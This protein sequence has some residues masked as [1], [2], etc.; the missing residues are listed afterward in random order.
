MNIWKD[1]P[2]LVNRET[3]IKITMWYYYTPT[4]MAKIKKIKDIKQLKSSYTAE[5]NV[6]WHNYSGKQ[7]TSYKVKHIWFYNCTPRHY[8][9]EREKN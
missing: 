8:S 6:K 5:R 2:H 9:K 1:V 7:A 3:Q 4:R